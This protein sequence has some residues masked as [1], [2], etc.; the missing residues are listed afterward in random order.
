MQTRRRFDCGVPLAL[1]ILGLYTHNTCIY[2]YVISAYI[3]IYTSFAQRPN[4]TD[5]QSGT[6]PASSMSNPKH[7]AAERAW[8]AHQSRLPLQKS[9]YK[10]FRGTVKWEFSQLQQ[11]R[12]INGLQYVSLLQASGKESPTN[13]PY[14]SESACLR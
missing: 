14:F 5:M 7:C 4:K 2:I 1:S 13:D 6:A 8:K 12:G 3:C 11:K 10:H 9:D